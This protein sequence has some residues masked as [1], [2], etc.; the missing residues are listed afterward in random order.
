MQRRA[1][2]P[3]CDIAFVSFLT[4]ASNVCMVGCVLVREASAAT[5]V[6]RSSAGRSF[7]SHH[8][9]IVGNNRK[10]KHGM[11]KLIIIPTEAVLGWLPWRGAV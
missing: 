6:S 3:H 11:C 8:I 2:K 7:Q 4:R 10:T 5:L 9:E 1:S